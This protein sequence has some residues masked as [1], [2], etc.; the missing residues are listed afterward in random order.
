MLESESVFA[1]RVESLKTMNNF[2]DGLFRT[3]VCNDTSKL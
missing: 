2:A 3:S 1:R